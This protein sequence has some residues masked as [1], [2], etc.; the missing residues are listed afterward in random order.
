MIVGVQQCSSQTLQKKMES[1]AF[2]YQGERH[3]S[4]PQEHRYGKA[5]SSFLY[6]ASHCFLTGHISGSVLYLDIFRYISCV[7]LSC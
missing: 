6:L 5:P 7:F 2:Q 3:R 1:S 4:F